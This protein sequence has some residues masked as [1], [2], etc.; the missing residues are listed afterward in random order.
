MTEPPLFPPGRLSGRAV[1]SVE[2]GGAVDFLHGLTTTEIRDVRPGD[3]RY[4]ALLT[5]Q[6]KILHDF[7]L[8]RTRS[9][10]FVDC[11]ADQQAELMQKLAFYRLRAKIAI[12]A[13]PDL[14]VWVS[15]TQPDGP[16]SFSDPRTPLLGFRAIEAADSSPQ[17]VSPGYRARRIFLGIAEADEIG[18]GKMFPHEANLDQLQGVS[19]SKGCFVGQE[20]VARMEHRGTARSRIVPVDFSTEVAEAGGDI[21]ANGLNLGG[22]VAV[23]GTM[24]LALLRLD[25]LGDAASAGQGL[26]TGPAIVRVRK[27]PWA[28]FDVPGA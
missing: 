9:G 7:L 4:G 1:L 28:K 27:P 21:S 16:G 3:S 6:G 15:M 13:R 12:D 5:P 24:G 10:F 22:L 19:F 20:V 18:Q 2:G 26:L 11:A 14:A 25:R 17:D 8:L 23:C